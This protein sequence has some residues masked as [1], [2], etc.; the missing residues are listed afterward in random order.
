MSI[1]TIYLFTTYTTYSHIVVK[2]QDES[3]GGKKPG[4]GK[5]RKLVDKKRKRG[6]GICL[7]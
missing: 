3:D 4:Y 6:G 2:F 5:K 1:L 7:G